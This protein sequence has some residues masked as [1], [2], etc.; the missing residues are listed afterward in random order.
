[1]ASAEDRDLLVR[2]VRPLQRMANYKFDDYGGYGPGIKFLETLAIWLRQFEPVERDIALQFVIED[3][4]FL[5]DREIQ[6]ALALAYQ[7]LVRPALIRESA[8]EIGVDAWR[9]AQV[10]GSE[11]FRILQ[12][13]TMF[14]GLAD[15][16]RLDQFRRAN[17]ALVHEQFSITAEP[18]DRVAS[19]LRDDLGKWLKKN[20]LEADVT[21]N[22]FV[23]IDDFSGSGFTA[24]RQDSDDLAWGGKLHHVHT[25]LQSLVERKI[26]AP[27]FAAQVLLYTASEQ[28]RDTL[29][30]RLRAAGLGWPVDVV[31]LIPNG[32]LVDPDSEFAGICRKYHDPYVDDKVKSDAAS[33]SA[34]LGFR[35]SRLPLVLSHNTP[36]NSVGIL[37]ENTVDE[38]ESTCQFTP[39]FPRHERH[40]ADR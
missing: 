30:D 14:M 37:W 2:T 6:H 10:L 8:T 35:Q 34:A 23:L 25:H 4:I 20:R 16:A 27:D 40:K 19:G 1:M 31:Q 12:R 9:V 21:F 13:R 33:A 36:N 7:D 17:P 18:P 11:A 38:P 5:S 26:A 15:G 22:R 28:A 29:R 32:S 39:L 3:L 24:L